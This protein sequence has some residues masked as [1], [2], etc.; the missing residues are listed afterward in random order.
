MALEPNKSIHEIIIRHIGEADGRAIY[1]LVCEEHEINA[2]GH[3][4]E[5]LASL[6]IKHLDESYDTKWGRS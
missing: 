3:T 1:N 4:S 6:L 5:T 2:W